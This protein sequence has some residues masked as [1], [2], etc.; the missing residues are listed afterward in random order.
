[1]MTRV[2]ITQKPNTPKIVTYIKQR[3]KKNKNML[4]CFTGGTGSGKSYSA[5]RLGELIGESLGVEFNTD[6]ITFEPGE[7]MRM[8]NSD[9]MRRGSVLILD[10]AGVVINARTWQSKINMMINYLTQTFRHRNYITIFCVP[11]MSFIDKAVRKLFHCYMETENVDYTKKVC[12]CKPFMLQNNQRTGNTYFKYLRFKVPGKGVT[13]LERVG[14]SLPNKELLDA[15]EEKKLE[16]T[17]R[18]NRDIEETINEEQGEILPDGKRKLTELQSKCYYLKEKHRL[19][20]EDIGLVLGI[21]NQTVN[22]HLKA[23]KKKRW[24]VEPLPKGVSAKVSPDRIEEL[25]GELS[26]IDTNSFLSN[27]YRNTDGAYFDINLETPRKSEG[28]K[29]D[30]RE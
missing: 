5:I 20:D 10:E 13:K 16:F 19:R 17:G 27:P 3:I 24:E 1:M 6:Y 9:K 26:H 21:A 18:L 15:Y 22:H 28:E 25:K 29:E 11:D 12:W 8:V 14:F 4:I 2:L 7:F 30:K 23:C